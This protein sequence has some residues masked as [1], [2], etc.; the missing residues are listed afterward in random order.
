MTMIFERSMAIFLVGR[1]EK[2]TKKMGN[3]LVILAVLIS[4]C[5]CT[6]ALSGTNF[7]AQQLSVL[8]GPTTKGNRTEIL[9]YFLVVVHVA[10]LLAMAFIYIIHRR[11]Q[12]LDQTLSVRFQICEN[13]TSSRLLFTLSILHLTIYSIYPIVL[14]YL[15][16]EFSQNAI[17][18]NLY[19]FYINV[20]YL[21]T[22]YTFILPLITVI[23][24]KKTRQIRRSKIHSMIEMKTSGDE[25]WTTYST[26]LQKQWSN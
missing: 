21:V 8:I 26:Q 3:F 13:Q 19:L 14:W 16:N 1:Y 7:Q 10:G 2:F 9:N 4:A 22:I 23:F 12:R 15:Q 25:G 18:I 5:E 24:L 20:A 17:P 11:H 6:W